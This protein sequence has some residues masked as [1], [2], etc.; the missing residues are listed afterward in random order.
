MH[1]QLRDGKFSTVV[2]SLLNRVVNG[3]IVGNAADV[4]LLNQIIQQE[5]LYIISL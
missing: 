5:N 2:E 1:V 3:F 4:R